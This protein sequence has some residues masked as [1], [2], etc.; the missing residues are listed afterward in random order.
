M[1]TNEWVKVWH[2]PDL[3]NLELHHARYIKHTFARHMHDYYVIGVIEVGT[4]AFWCQGTRYIN[5]AGGVFI[6]NPGE[7]HTGEG[8]D[9][10]GFTYRTL[11]PDGTL[12]QR[13]V[14]EIVGREQPLPFFSTPVIRD[15]QLARHILSLHR[16]LASSL[17]PLE[18]ESRFLHTFAHLITHYA[19]LRSPKQVAG[20]ERHEVQKVQQYIDAYYMQRVT[21]TE[22]AQLV[23]WSPY[24]LL[25]VFEKEIGIPPHAY[26]ESVR[27][28]QAQRL[29]SQGVPLAQVAY[30]LGFSHQSHLTNR[31]KRLL[32]V[33]PGQYLQQH[34]I[35]QDGKSVSP[36]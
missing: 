16:A 2:D 33:T 26:L 3:N 18:R 12:L 7:A 22:L 21:L 17:S 4:Q 30:D 13:A 32:G 20:K 1:E 35:V 6:I 19:E 28:R 25:R 23:N 27:I 36:V 11:Y 10:H 34:K 29:L 24:Y 31:F 9:E 14:A 8:A 15:P 5:P